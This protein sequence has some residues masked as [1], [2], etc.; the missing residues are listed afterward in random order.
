[1]RSTNVAQDLE[2]RCEYFRSRS[3]QMDLFT[4]EISPLALRYIQFG[5]GV[6]CFSNILVLPKV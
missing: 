3:R 2:K 6:L 4:K 1:M 5:R